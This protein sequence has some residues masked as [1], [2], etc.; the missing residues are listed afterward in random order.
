MLLASSGPSGILRAFHEAYEARVEYPAR[1]GHLH[2]LLVDNAC[3]YLVCQ[4]FTVAA[5]L[6][7]L[8]AFADYSDLAR[9]RWLP[10]LLGAKGSQ[11]YPPKWLGNVIVDDTTCAALGL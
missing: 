3:L 4:R 1:N 6:S 8:R 10:L 9:H 2:A 7:A 11:S 5:W